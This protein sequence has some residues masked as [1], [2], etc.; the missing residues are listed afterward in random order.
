[1]KNSFLNA[2]V[3]DLRDSRGFKG[4]IGAIT[5]KTKTVIGFSFC[6]T[7]FRFGIIKLYEQTNH[8]DAGLGMSRR[9][10]PNVNCML[11]GGLL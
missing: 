1:M 6:F 9:E 4:I 10:A 11:D 5:I 8:F 3:S 7:F 2:F